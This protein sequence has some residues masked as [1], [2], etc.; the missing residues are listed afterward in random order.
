[1]SSEA[2]S[3][4]CQGLAFLKATHPKPF[5]LLMSSEAQSGECQ[6][7]AFLKATHPRAKGCAALAGQK[8][9]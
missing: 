9:E 1:M 8:D 7:L 6:G 3:G 4:E 2:Q 5:S